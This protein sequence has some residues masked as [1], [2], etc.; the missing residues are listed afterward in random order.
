MPR[1]KPS[2]ED[3][4]LAV[5]LES[6]EVNWAEIWAESSEAVERLEERV[7]DVVSYTEE[8]LSETFVMKSEV[9][10]LTPVKS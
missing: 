3:C 8:T 10:F 5:V 2:A 1:S 6:D 4:M 7:L 9:A